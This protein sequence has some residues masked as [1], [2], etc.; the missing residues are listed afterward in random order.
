MGLAILPSLTFCWRP[1]KCY[2]NRINKC[3]TL[4]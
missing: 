4:R 3:M 2:N 1:P